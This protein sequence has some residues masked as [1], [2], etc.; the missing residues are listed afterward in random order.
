MSRRW[1]PSRTQVALPLSALSIA[2]SSPFSLTGN[3]CVATLASGTSCTVTVVFTPVANGVV[4]GALTVSSYGF[5]NA[6]TIALIGAGGAAGSIQTQPASLVFP[7]TGVGA[8]SATQA[9]T[10]TNNGP[11]SILSLNLAASVGFQAVSHELRCFTRSRCR[12]HCADRIRPVHRGAA[13]RKPDNLE[14]FSGPE[15]NCQPIR[16]RPRLHRLTFRSF[17]PDRAKRSNR[18]LHAQRNADGRIERDL[19]LFV[20]RF[21]G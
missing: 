5:I 17:Q 2:V 21:S 1:Q 13:D 11:I 7:T 6:A 18:E 3:S 20:H 14:F 12:L 16:N 19:H 4:N 8:K 15:L 9:V 10:L